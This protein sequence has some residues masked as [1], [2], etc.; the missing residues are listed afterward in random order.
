MQYFVICTVA[1]IT[2]G[3]TLFSGFG[4]GTLLMLFGGIYWK[5]PGQESDA[6]SDTNSRID[7]AHRNCYRFGDGYHIKNL[8]SR[9]LHRRIII[10]VVN[11]SAAG[12]EQARLTTSIRTFKLRFA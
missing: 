12:Q 5:P 4:L 2:S 11:G 9:Q 7:H 10:W 6:A 8:P 3:L 1:L